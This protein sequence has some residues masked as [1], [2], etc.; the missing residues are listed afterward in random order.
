MA[1][2]NTNASRLAALVA[3]APLLVGAWFAAPLILPMWRWQ[4]VDFE[5]VAKTT[6]KT[7]AELEKR[8]HVVFRYSE[9]GP[10]DPLPWQLLEMKPEW[11]GADE[12]EL[13]VR[14]AIISDRTG[15]PVGA[16]SLGSGHYKDRYFQ[17]DAWRLPPGS[18]G[19]NKHRPV[20]LFEHSTLEKLS[21]SQSGG[22]D[23]KVG[24][25]KNQ[26]WTSDDDTVEDGYTAPE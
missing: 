21:I 3:V 18:L 8:Y 6:G 23:E 26:H 22:W 17:A 19:F 10:G 20:I 12:K 1:A 5:K 14:A 4:N 7:Q 16:L 13:T 11:E 9:R 2:A 15:E 25:G 24:N